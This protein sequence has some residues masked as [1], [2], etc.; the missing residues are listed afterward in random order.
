MTDPRTRTPA[1]HLIVNAAGLTEFGNTAPEMPALRGLM[2]HMVQTKPL[3]CADDSP[4]T[5]FELTLARAQGLHQEPGLIPWAA[6]DTQTYA[7]PCAWITPCHCQVGADHALL[8]DPAELSLD[9]ASSRALMAAAAPYFQEDGIALHYHR[10]DAWLATGALFRGLPTRSL[11][12]VVHRRITT[13]FFDGSTPA[14]ILLRRLQNEMQMLFYSHPVYDERQARGL[15]GVNTFWLH[16]AGE[17]D[18]SP[19]PAPGVNVITA[20]LLDPAN[21]PNS[22]ASVLSAW[23]NFDAHTL[24]P[25]LAKVQQGLDLRLTLCG[26]HQALSYQT[27]PRSWTARLLQ[28][29]GR[30]PALPP[31]HQL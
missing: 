29:L 2:V 5:P 1:T 22:T 3:Q 10:P 16:G 21:P 14:A 27:A 24:R 19:T 9:E 12:Q 26:E 4:A 18:A 28:T 25:L 31:L 15:L 8:R 11:Q 6:F 17:L 23:Q 20:T 7:T 13:A 30:R